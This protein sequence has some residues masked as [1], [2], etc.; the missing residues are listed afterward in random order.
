MARSV[1]VLRRRCSISPLEESALGEASAPILL[2]Q[3]RPANDITAAV[4]PGQHRIGAMLPYSPLHHLLFEGHDEVLVMTSGNLSDRPQIIADD[5]A[6]ATF[7]GIADAILGHDRRIAVRVDD[8]VLRFDGRTRT[9]LRLGRG[10]APGRL[11][12]PPGLEGGRDLVAMGAQLKATF[13][14]KRSNRLIL[15]QHIG[16]LDHAENLEAFET[17]LEH[18]LRLWELAPEAIAIDQHPD[19][20]SGR[21]G[22]ALAERTGATLIEVQHHHGHAAACLAEHGWPVDEAPALAIV[23]DGLGYGPDGSLW[24]GEFLA[25]DYAG[26]RRLAHLRPIAM[27]GGAAAIREPWRMAAAHLATIGD[28]EELRKEFPDLALFRCHG[29]EQLRILFEAARR[30]INAPMTSSCGRLFDAVAALVGVRERVTY[31]GQAAAELEATLWR[32]RPVAKARGGYTMALADRAGALPVID[33]RP[34]WRPILADLT[35]GRALSEV[36]LKFHFGL[37][38]TLIQMTEHL[39][40]HHLELRR[41]PIVLS[42]GVFQNGYLL[43]A[44]RSRLARRGWRVLTHHVVPP[45]DGGLAVGQAAVAAAVAKGLNSTCA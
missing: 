12:A 40:D 17:S 45:N 14:L 19:I 25:V 1:G 11:P 15:S 24:G 39:L 2:L 34:I 43:R 29:R 36:A 13:C 33:P 21:I 10:F 44:L 8:S 22:R 20:A 28:L 23:L 16:D 32:E 26:Y 6:R 18:D 30:G 5:E 31:E 7:A 38:D 35:A 4:A 3:P 42:G 41:S 27:P 37:V 9:P